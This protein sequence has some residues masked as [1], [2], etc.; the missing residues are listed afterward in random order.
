MAVSVSVFARLQFVNKDGQ[1]LVQQGR[2][3]RCQSNGQVTSRHLKY[4]NIV[5]KVLALRVLFANVFGLSAAK[6]DS[7]WTIL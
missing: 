5:G 7:G 2:V 1:R 3:N 4:A 6:I